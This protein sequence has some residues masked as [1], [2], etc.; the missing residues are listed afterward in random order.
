MS[1]NACA[2]AAAALVAVLPAHAV[3]KCTQ[4]DGR[5]V[6]S[7][8][9]C[10]AGTKQAQIVSPAPVIAPM[11]PRPTRPPGQQ[12]AI[13]AAERPTL[14]IPPPRRVQ[15]SGLPQSDLSW[16]AATLDKIRVQGR[17][18]DWA[19]RVD[20]TKMQACVDFLARMQPGGEFEQIRERVLLALRQEPGVARRSKQD[21]D[22]I[23]IFKREAL[24][25][26]ASA[27]ANLSRPGR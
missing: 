1:W 16:S 8:A 13:A 18:C 20:K 26:Q 6:Y 25:Y 21:L 15:F 19:L 24:D 10:A 2:I 3:N 22:K 27:M 14:Q 12:G 4:P 9:P 5:V 17:D 11:S 23:E 7:D